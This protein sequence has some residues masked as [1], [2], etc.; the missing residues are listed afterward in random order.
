MSTG[1]ANVRPFIER[2]T[3]KYSSKTS[4][5][6]YMAVTEG[7][8]NIHKQMARSTFCIQPPG[9]TLTRKSFYESV[10][11]GCIPVVFRND[12][13]FVSQLAFASVI[14]WWNI[15]VY[16]DESR[17]LSGV[18]IIRPADINRSVIAE[19]QE[20]ILQYKRM[21]TF[22]TDSYNDISNPDAFA[23]TLRE[24]SREPIQTSSTSTF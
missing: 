3:I 21:I 24:L 4:T 6:R 1:C 9:D 20:N 10:I 17:V 14:P 16:I 12:S 2:L 23:M 7:L 15:F 11:L 19:R 8:G 18:D 22:S 5:V 13:A